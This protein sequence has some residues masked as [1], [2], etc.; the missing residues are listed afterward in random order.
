MNAT[1]REPITPWL[2]AVTIAVPVSAP[3]DCP[4]GVACFFQLRSRTVAA[5]HGRCK[6]SDGSSYDPG[7]ETR[8][9]SRH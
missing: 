2:E 4:L 9:L 3:A 6:T 8:A 5:G 1:E 7:P